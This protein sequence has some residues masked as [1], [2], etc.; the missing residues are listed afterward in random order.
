MQVNPAR[1]I[2]PI[3]PGPLSRKELMPLLILL[4][5]RIHCLPNHILKGFGLRR[6]AKT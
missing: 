3:T 6:E 4:D 5:L 1:M 2:D